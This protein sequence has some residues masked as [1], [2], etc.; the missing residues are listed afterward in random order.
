MNLVDDL[1]RC[2]QGEIRIIYTFS[3]LNS[4]NNTLS[5]YGIMCKMSDKS[6]Q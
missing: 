2:W 1:L 4:L 5:N 3:K 6:N